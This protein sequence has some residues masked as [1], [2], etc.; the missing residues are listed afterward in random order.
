MLGPGDMAVVAPEHDSRVGIL[1][2]EPQQV[3][4]HAMIP[5][6]DSLVHTQVLPDERDPLPQHCPV[7]CVGN[8]RVDPGLDRIEPLPDLSGQLRVDLCAA[9]VVVGQYLVQLRGD[10]VQPLCGCG[11]LAQH[12]AEQCL[13]PVGRLYVDAPEADRMTVDVPLPHPF[14]ERQHLV[15]IPDPHAQSEEPG[16]CRPAAAADVVVQ[17]DTLAHF[18]FEGYQV[19]ALPGGQIADQAL[20]HA[21]DLAG[22]VGVLTQRDHLLRSDQPVE[23]LHLRGVPIGRITPFQRVDVSPQ[24]RFFPSRESA[25]GGR[26]VRIAEFP[27]VD[28]DFEIVEPGAASAFQ[29]AADPDGGRRV[30]KLSADRDAAPLRRTAHPAL[31]GV[32]RETAVVSLPGEDEKQIGKSRRDVLRTDPAAQFDFA[33]GCQRVG[34]LLREAGPCVFGR[35]DLFQTQAGTAVFPA[36]AVTCGGVAVIGGVGQAPLGRLIPV[37]GI[38]EIEVELRGVRAVAASVQQGVAEEQRACKDSC[39]ET[40]HGR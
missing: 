39:R 32:G 17:R 34:Q 23:Y 26:D 20:L 10:L 31:R 40:V 21:E 8:R 27:A 28:P 25:F 4:R 16:H 12:H 37:V 2:A 19:K 6:V 36:V 29:H 13:G 38:F 9:F 14:D 1:S 30:G 11:I 15:R 22:S 3:L 24:L 33:A 35:V 18:G 7:V 5:P